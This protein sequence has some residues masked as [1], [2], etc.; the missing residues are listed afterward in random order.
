MVQTWEHPISREALVLM[1]LFD[2]LH[3][4]HTHKTQ[5]PHGGRPKSAR[6]LRRMAGQH[7]DHAGRT[8][9]QIMALLRP[10]V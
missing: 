5:E 4:A 10:P 9:A 1:D 3:V 8:P 2:L 6:D 7:G